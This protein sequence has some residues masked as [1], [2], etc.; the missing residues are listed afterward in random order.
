[1]T[2]T[3]MS[4]DEIVSRSRLWLDLTCMQIWE[5]SATTFDA[6]SNSPLEEAVIKGW[7]D[8][9]MKLLEWVWDRIAWED[10]RSLCTY[11]EDVCMPGL[12]ILLQ[13]PEDQEGSVL[14]DICIHS[15]YP[16]LKER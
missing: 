14:C 4:L 8:T 5:M 16:S 9:P 12:R 1:M 10:G 3:M 6:L 11:A 2:A 7:T 15:A 13:G